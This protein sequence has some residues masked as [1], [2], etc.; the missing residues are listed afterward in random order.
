ML[1]DISWGL[2]RRVR[3][4]S[5]LQYDDVSEFLFIYYE[6]SQLINHEV[7]LPDALDPTTYCR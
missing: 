2:S 6:F 5:K 1:W 3:S 7:S 4:G